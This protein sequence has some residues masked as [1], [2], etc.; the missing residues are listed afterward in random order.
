ME[1]NFIKSKRKIQVADVIRIMLKFI[2]YQPEVIDV[3]QDM[4]FGEAFGCVFYVGLIIYQ[5]F[6]YIIRQHPV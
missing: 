6:D 1:N 2:Q 5:W 3:L 4:P